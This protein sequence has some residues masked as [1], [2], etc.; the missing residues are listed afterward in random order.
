MENRAL[1]RGPQQEFV[2]WVRADRSHAR[3]ASILNLDN[4]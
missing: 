1:H 2:R 3:P 4:M